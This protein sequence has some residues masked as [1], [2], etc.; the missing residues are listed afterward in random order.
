MLFLV[1]RYPSFY[2]AIST[3]ALADALLFMQ[4]V[5]YSFRVVA[6]YPPEKIVPG[7][8]HKTLT[9]LLV[10]IN[11]AVSMDENS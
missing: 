6:C 5:R 2:A 4:I 1:T 3:S 7:T 10:I 9:N 11:L 8:F